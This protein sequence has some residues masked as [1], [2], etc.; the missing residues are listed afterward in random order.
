MYEVDELTKYVTDLVTKKEETCAKADSDEETLFAVMLR[1]KNENGLEGGEDGDEF[2]AAAYE[3]AE[4]YCEGVITTISIGATKELARL[5]MEINMLPDDASPKQIKKIKE[6]V[7][8]AGLAVAHL[9]QIVRPAIDLVDYEHVAER[10]VDVGRK[11]AKSAG[12]D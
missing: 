8:T 4:L 3:A 6:R 12:A 5:L 7:G 10:A 1:A 11:M 9:M 2:P